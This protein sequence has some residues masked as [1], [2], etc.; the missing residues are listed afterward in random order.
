[1]PL[2][3]TQ[4]ELLILMRFASG[5]RPLNIRYTGDTVWLSGENNSWAHQIIRY[6]RLVAQLKAEGQTD[7][8]IFKAVPY[9]PPSVIIYGWVSFVVTQF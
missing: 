4:E 9:E 5:S 6:L 1:M 7:E 2:K 3:L 8:Q